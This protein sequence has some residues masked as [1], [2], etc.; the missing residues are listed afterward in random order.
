MEATMA[1]LLDI[2]TGSF[3]RAL[4][5]AL[6]L[7]AATFI[8]SPGSSA[9]AA[10]TK[11]GDLKSSGYT[12]TTI[13][14]GFTEC[15]KDGSTTYWCDASGSCQPKPRTKPIERVVLPPSGGLSTAP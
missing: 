6:L 1:P 5:A 13:A 2:R 14:T 12:C 4:A 11:I 7:G 15:T 10:S 8:S 9:Y 3:S